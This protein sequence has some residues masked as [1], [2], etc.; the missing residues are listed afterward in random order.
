MVLRP[1]KS[2]HRIDVDSEEETKGAEVTAAAR[3]KSTR[4]RERPTYTESEESDPDTVQSWGMERLHTNEEDESV[5]DTDDMEVKQCNV[6]LD[7]LCDKAARREPEENDDMSRKSTK[8]ASRIPTFHKRPA[9]VSAEL[10]VSKKDPPVTVLHPADK[11]ASVDASKSK[12]PDARDKALSQQSI[13]SL[14]VGLDALTILSG[15][16]Q[17]ATGAASKGDMLS[18]GL[19]PSLVVSPRPALRGE[20]L[21]SPEENKTQRTEIDSTA[22]HLL[23]GYPL[24]HNLP[25]EET[26]YKP[27]IATKRSV[28]LAVTKE[29][30]CIPDVSQTMAIVD[31]K[32]PWESEDP[33]VAESKDRNSSSVIDSEDDLATADSQL[34]ADPNEPQTGKMDSEDVATEKAEI[35]HKS[36][37]PAVAEQPLTAPATKTTKGSG[38]RYF[39]LRFLLPV[40]LLLLGMHVWRFGLPTSVEQLAAHLELHWL[41]GMSHITEQCSRDCRVHLVESFPM[42]LYPSSPSPQQSTAASWLRL[43]DEANSSVSVAAFYVSLR[44]NKSAFVDTKG[45]KVFERL[46]QL[47]SKRVKLNIAVNAPQ[48]KTQDT[49]ELAA[50]GAN[51]REVDLKSLSGGILH[52]KLLVIDQKHFYLGSANMDWRSLSQVKEMGVAVE[53]CSCLAQDA[54]RIFDMYWSLSGSLPPYWPARFTALSSS[55]DPLHVNFNGVAA[56]VYFSSAPPQISAR[57]RSDDLTTILSVISDAQEFIFISVMDYLPLS[58][59]TKPLRFWPAIDSA[60]RAA[61]CSR[62]VKIRLLVSCWEHSPAA[63]FTFLQSLLV[64]NRPPMKCDI[65]VK[66]FTV[67][68]TAEQMMIPFARVNHAKYMVTDRVL[69]IGTSNWSENYFTKTAGVGLVVNQTDSQVKQGQWTLQSQAEELFLRDWRSHYASSL[70]AGDVRVCPRIPH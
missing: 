28:P 39:A 24:S 34:V 59:F 55:Q 66:I 49:S 70:S 40:T 36:A 51:I 32:P 37:C 62:S 42:G 50:A 31:E 12:F 44:S 64:L 58:E 48:T 17:A 56:K 4:L 25:Q 35:D 61:A 38:C 52:T 1:R 45:R 57:G 54:T 3:R 46:K 9:V 60:L 30:T 43:L 14:R 41:E 27:Y 26:P 21:L 6:V 13:R 15:A 8:P 11:A 65:E 53:D 20:E 19:Q 22:G 33:N 16:D 68:S 5:G 29:L 18:E 69:Y 2:M 10:P 67:P 23:C 47:S 63:M 7:R